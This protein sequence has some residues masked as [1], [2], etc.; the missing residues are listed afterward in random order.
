MTNE[1][2]LT[3]PHCGQR[4]KK[5]RT[6]DQT[7]WGTP[8]QY[9]CFNDDCPY[10]VRGWEWMRT[11]FNQK[12]SYRH[13]YDPSTGESGPVAVWSAQALRSGIIEENDDERDREAERT[14]P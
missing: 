11:H 3:C 13:R 9:V 1:K 8:F 14:D 4:L 10:Y 5:W 12:V 6:P 7:S 2:N